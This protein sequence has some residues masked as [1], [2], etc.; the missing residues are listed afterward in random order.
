MGIAEYRFR[1]ILGRFAARL[2]M[3]LLCS[4]LHHQ[5]SIPLP[6]FDI[7]SLQEIFW[8]KSHQNQVLSNFWDDTRVVAKANNLQEPLLVA[9]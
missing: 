3:D 8:H 4:T 9:R 1:Q 5:P 7:P 6:S 2:R